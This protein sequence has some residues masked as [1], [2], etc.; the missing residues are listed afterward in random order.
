MTIIV[1]LVLGLIAGWLASLI[2]GS[3]GYGLIGDIAVGILGAL[4]GGWLASTL[5]GVDVTGL[6]VTSVAVAVVGAMIL[7]AVF[8]AVAPGR[9]STV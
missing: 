9:R 3:G 6:N 7:I 2:M 8:R 1:W 4:L 5:L